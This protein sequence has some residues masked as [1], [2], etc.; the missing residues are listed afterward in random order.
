VVAGQD[1]AAITLG[2]DAFLGVSLSG[3]GTTLAGVLDGGA[4][5]SAGLGAGD[6]ITSVGGTAV[7]TYPELQKAVAAHDPGEQVRVTWTDASGTSH[8]ASVT[9]GRAPVA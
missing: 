5:E 2:Y 9:L 6:T 8:S 7:T 1:T 3:S 4:A